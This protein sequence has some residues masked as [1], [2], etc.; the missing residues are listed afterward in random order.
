MAPLAQNPV[1]PGL[2]GL[3]IQVGAKHLN[4]LVT[5]QS[6]MAHDGCGNSAMILRCYEALLQNTSVS[7]ADADA[8]TT[9]YSR[10]A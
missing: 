8:A 1:R 3:V 2:F 9:K 7:D 6:P 5:T 4:Q 10:M